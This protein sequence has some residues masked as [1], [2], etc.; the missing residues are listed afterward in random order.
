MNSRPRV[1]LVAGPTASGKSDFA[2][3]LA[4]EQ[5]GEIINADS[6]QFFRGLEI[7]T[8]KVPP[9]QR[10][11]RHW[12]LDLCEVGQAMTAMDFVKRADL[13]IGKLSQEGKVPIVVGGTG[14]YLRALFEGLDRLPPRDPK[15]R[16]KLEAQIQEQGTEFLH[17]RLQEVDPESARRISPK[18]PQRLVR[19]LEIFHLTGEA[20]SKLQKQGRPDRLRFC[21][22]TYWLRPDRPWLRNRIK[23]R[24]EQM[25]AAGWVREVEDLLKQQLDPRHWEHRPIGYA[26]LAEACSEGQDLQEVTQEI[27]RKTQQYAKRQETFF[28]G[29]FRGSAYQS[30]GSQIHLVEVPR[31]EGTAG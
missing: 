31:C 28:R 21:T 5:G 23:M 29:Q 11:V 1:L 30:H 14:L 27:I 6:Q 2:Q 3:K 9:Q 13:L 16:N 7:G 19:Y 22:Q 10:K 12:F 18:D 25:M 20:P 15:V 8:G 4:L 24:V 17:H 26:E